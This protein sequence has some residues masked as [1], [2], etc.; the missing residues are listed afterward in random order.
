MKTK[1]IMS[2]LII[3][4]LTFVIIIFL[5]Q[6]NF[7]FGQDPTFSQ[8]FTNRIYY[9]PAY[10]GS[11]PGMRTRLNYR[12]QWHNLS[13]QYNNYTL[14]IDVAEPNLPGAGG[15]GLIV[16]SDLDGFGNVKATAA[17]LLASVKIDFSEDFI[18][19]F[20]LGTSYVQRSIDWNGF[21]YSDQLD[22]R[23][24]KIK[25]ISDFPQPDF[26]KTT[27]PDFSAGILFRYCETSDY[28]KHI[29]ASIAISAQHVFKPDISFTGL[30][31]R[32]PMKLIVMGDLLLDNESSRQNIRGSTQKKGSEFKLNSGFLY[33]K[34]G[35]M[36][37]FSIGLNGYK[38]YIYTGAWVR[39]QSFT[40][41]RVHD[42]ILMVGLNLPFG[43]NSLIK[44][45][46]SY[47]YVLSQLRRTVGATH[48]IS[49]IYELTGFSFFGSNSIGH[50]R[51]LS[52]GTSTQ[53]CANCPLF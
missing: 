22:P 52:G 4:T 11:H 41:Q 24:G 9:N 32:L 2:S 31:A 34:Q 25:D 10:A 20:G 40:F 19:L 26:Y 23:Y 50:R 5:L 15:L 53:N 29:I 6:T 12:N 44:L 27:Y 7:L 36:T 42:L 43:D 39:T 17:S 28:F 3:K 51:I 49:L 1:Q 13:S 21:T 8:F 30:P 48:E 35:Q 46:Y 16:H 14:A 47:D 45:R 38:N 33:E 37:N 18:T